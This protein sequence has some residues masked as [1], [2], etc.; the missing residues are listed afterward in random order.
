MKVCLICFAYFVHLTGAPVL[1]TELWLVP[2]KNSRPLCSAVERRLG[3]N[4]SAAGPHVPLWRDPED[5]VERLF[6]CRRRER[7]AG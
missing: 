3:A 6:T 7:D 1:S 2:L 5:E 4:R